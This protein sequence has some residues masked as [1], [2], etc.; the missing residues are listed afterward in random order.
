MSKDDKDGKAAAEKKAA[1]ARAAAAKTAAAVKAEAD[2]NSPPAPENE[3][4]TEELP[5]KMVEGLKEAGF[6]P[7]HALATATY[8]EQELWTVV[9]EDAKRRLKLEISF[10]GKWLNPPPP[11]KEKAKAKK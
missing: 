2:K 3:Q 6:G 5:P 9:A 1:D 4:L 10:E 8:K 7:Q 11:P